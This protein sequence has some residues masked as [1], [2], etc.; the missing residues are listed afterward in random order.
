MT[1]SSLE[2]RLTEAI[3]KANNYRWLKKAG[4]VVALF[5]GAVALGAWGVP[6]AIG[7]AVA[8]KISGIH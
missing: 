5:T 2:F 6:T 1:A 3:V 4:L 7:Y 8:A